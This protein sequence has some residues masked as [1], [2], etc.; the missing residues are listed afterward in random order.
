MLP[1]GGGGTGTRISSV[2]RGAHSP[3]QDPTRAAVLRLPGP[4]E[5][6]FFFFFP[7]TCLFCGGTAI[8]LAAALIGEPRTGNRLSRANIQ[9]AG[10]P[11]P[12]TTVKRTHLSPRSWSRRQSCSPGVCATTNAHSLCREACCRRRRVQGR[13]RSGAPRWLQMQ[14]WSNR[15]VSGW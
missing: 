11:S 6:T 8:L 5:D 1:A 14:L 12:R 13:Q 3:S 4:R 9:P 10:T 15:A 2:W 7:C